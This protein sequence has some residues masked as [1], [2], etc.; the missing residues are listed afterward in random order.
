[1]RASAIR[2]RVTALLALLLMTAMSAGGMERIEISK[3]KTG[4]VL[5][6]SA[7]KFVPW[8]LN[9]GNAGRLIE[10]FWE[11]EW[12]TV[13]R[14]WADMKGMGANVVRVHLQFGKF[15]ETAER[16]NE[17]ALAMLAKLLAL[18]EKTGIYL[19]LT[20]LACYRK[21]DVPGWYDGLSEADRWAA[22]A[23]FWGAVAKTC[24]KSPA[25]FCYDL[26]NEAITAGGKRKPGEWY[27]GKLLGPYD[28][29]QVCRSIREI[30]S[31]RRLG[32]TGFG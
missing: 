28:F 8:G 2:M 27:S 20:G 5:A 4:F 16:P 21:A 29:I 30:G 6:P 13:E 14:D 7:A 17:K 32:A 1:M 12:G 9:Y 19:D 22:Q 23:R 24:E 26:M 15:M 3:D 25:V 18:S 31:A 11:T 10:D